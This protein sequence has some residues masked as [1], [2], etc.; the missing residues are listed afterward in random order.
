[1][2]APKKK[3][4]ASVAQS[5]KGVGPGSTVKGKTG[6]KSVPGAIKPPPKMSVRRKQSMFGDGN[7]E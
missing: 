5:A 4:A 6:A 7:G 2:A 1:M 3:V